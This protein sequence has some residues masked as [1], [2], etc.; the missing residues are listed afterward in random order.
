MLDRIDSE[1]LIDEVHSYQKQLDANSDYTK[2]RRWKTAESI[3]EFFTIL[4][5]T[6]G[7]YLYEL[8][9]NCRAKKISIIDTRT[10]KI[11]ADYINGSIVWNQNLEE[12][13]S[14]IFFKL[15]FHSINLP[16]GTEIS[17]SAAIAF[18]NGHFND[19]SLKPQK[20]YD[21]N[22][23]GIFGEPGENE[24]CNWMLNYG[25]MTSILISLTMFSSTLF[26]NWRTL[27]DIT[28][29]N[30]TLKDQDYLNAYN[31][32]DDLLFKLDEDI[33]E[34]DRNEKEELHKVNLLDK[35]YNPYWQCP[36]SKRL[37][38][39]PFKLISADN[40][41]T[42]YDYNHIDPSIKEKFRN[43][44]TRTQV[45]E[46]GFY[47]ST[48]RAHKA[49]VCDLYEKVAEI[50]MRKELSSRKIRRNYS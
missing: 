28:T 40:R 10:G 24:A 19:I 49:Y 34:L 33:Y 11:F 22:A 15:V 4:S 6:V 1:K 27:F 20:M 42:R 39:Q 36:I 3:A 35:D 26:W 41:Q 25:D 29:A 13:Y 44:S 47:E 14:K 37:I 46:Y 8:A 18:I 30:P 21:R 7:Y 17:L 2:L 32:L 45:K 23:N 43:P 12:L 48:N 38:V 9:D 50:K 5:L 31:A 16:S